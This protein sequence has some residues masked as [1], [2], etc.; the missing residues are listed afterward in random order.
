MSYKA[1]VEVI[2][3]FLRTIL[4]DVIRNLKIWKARSYTS[5]QQY[6]FH[7][8]LVELGF[9]HTAITATNKKNC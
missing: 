6:Q 8:P 7:L 3:I 2:G 5:C 4:T 1:Q 9:I